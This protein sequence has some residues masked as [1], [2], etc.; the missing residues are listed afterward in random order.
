[1]KT[2][3]TS[4]LLLAFAGL[5]GAAFPLQAQLP[6]ITSQPAHAVKVLKGD[7]Q[8]TATASQPSLSKVWL[9]GTTAVSGSAGLADGFGSTTLNLQKLSTSSAG[10]Y[11]ARFITPG[12]NV[13][14]D[15]A[16]LGI[17]TSPPALTNL[18]T[19]SALTLTCSATVPTGCTASFQWLDHSNGQNITN[20]GVISGAD[21]KSIKIT[22]LTTALETAAITA[23][24]GY[25]AGGSAL[26]RFRCRVTMTLPA[27]L[28][29]GMV[30][31]LSNTSEVN[32]VA[33]PEIN[34]SWNLGSIPVSMLVEDQVSTLKTLPGVPYTYS[35]TG[36]PPGVK[37]D[38]K[39][40]LITGKPTTPKRDKLGAVIPYPVVFTI[41]SAF[42]KGS[43]TM[44]WTIL[45]LQENLIG[46]IAGLVERQ[47]THT[48]GLGGYCQLTVGTTGACTGHLILHGGMKLP[49]TGSV[50]TL[51]TTSWSIER[52][53]PLL[54]PLT[55]SI[56]LNL[57]NQNGVLTGS[58]TDYRF[59]NWTATTYVG[60]ATTG[61]GDGPLLGS[62]LNLP[63][64]VLY[65]PAL[66]LLIADRL[67]DRIARED[68]SNLVTFVG[69]TSGF[70]NGTGTAAQLS[71]PSGL[72]MHSDGTIYVTDKN[73]HAVRKITPA[74]VVTT[75]AGTGTEGSE[76]GAGTTARFNDPNGIALDPAGNV[77]VCD[78]DNF[79][80]RKI[81]PAGVVSTLAGKVGLQSHADG[82]GA[83]ARFNSPNGIAYEPASKCLYVTDATCIRRI[84]LTGAVT[85][86]AGLSGGGE[87]NEGML[88]NARF[89]SLASITADGL[90]GLYVGGTSNIY[91]ITGG[92]VHRIHRDTSVAFLTFSGL[93]SNAAG[94]VFASTFSNQRVRW[95][96]E[97]NYPSAELNLF[98]APYT[99]LAPPPSGYVGYHTA[100]LV[101]NTPTAYL[102]AGD[103]YLTLTTTNVG[104]AT[105]TGRH[106]DGTTLIGGGLLG[107][108]G[109][110][111]LH[112]PLA[113]GRGTFQGIIRIDSTLG[114]VV[115]VGSDSHQITLPAGASRLYFGQAQ[116]FPVG[117]QGSRYPA[118]PNLPSLL[119]VTAGTS[120][121]R[122]TILKSDGSG[123]LFHL[124]ANLAANN[125]ITLPATAQNPNLVTLKLNPKTGILT[126]GYKRAATSTAVSRSGTFAGVLVP[127]QSMVLGYHILPDESAPGTP[128][129]QV[130]TTSGFVSFR[131]VP[132]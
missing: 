119:G 127:S 68:G 117:I 24:G 95:L 106:P 105:W 62:R 123:E 10:I 109:Q 92:L 18:K 132:N 12:G 69:G 101:N 2:S 25:T 126:G 30:N 26:L 80:I 120:N 41:S 78:T 97:S 86:F 21:T 100:N 51:T 85:T 31:G 16:F 74:G 73:N 89:G 63:S 113:A 23:V 6:T 99:K 93:A 130:E 33:P 22:N 15:P 43:R 76:N 19:G 53:L 102:P 8:F 131:N 124:D 9:K 82:S 58:I 13:E 47:R 11:K 125:A 79:I 46:T 115:N 116:T 110:L 37:L 5:L 71:S 17:I 45:P 27:S 50:D 83:S 59:T 67:N 38:G 121:V 39:T 3:Y 66:G 103:G 1:M 84:T 48:S 87:E 35:A 77:Y 122:L 34:P 88:V 14:S 129:A 91:H 61:S 42:G 54:K 70:T 72:A 28:G 49:I 44:N 60:D 98:R 29:G 108:T 4:T 90:G 57:G 118:A 36:L 65:H 52:D 64:G 128:A 20:G 56:R 75:L 111:A 107:I 81:T 94:S 104:T 7:V 40:G 112:H 55:G 114:L 32:L 96:R